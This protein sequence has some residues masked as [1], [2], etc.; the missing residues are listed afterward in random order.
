MNTRF[1][2]ATGGFSSPASSKHVGTQSS[3]AQSLEL[4][5]Q[6]RIDEVSGLREAMRLQEQI[7]N[8]NIA[9]SNLQPSQVSPAAQDAQQKRTDRLKELNYTREKVHMLLQQITWDESAGFRDRRYEQGTK[10]SG[11]AKSKSSRRKHEKDATP[12]ISA[13]VRK[14]MESLNQWVSQDRNVLDV[15]CG[16]GLL[17]DFIENM[18][19][20]HYH[21]ID[22]S[23][24]MI[25]RAR[26][27]LPH[28]H[29][30]QEDFMSF[31]KGA[32]TYS[33]IVFNEC[34]HYMLEPYQALQKAIEIVEPS[35][36]VIVSHPK[37]Y[38]HVNM[39]R[40]KNGMLVASLL[41]TTD[42]LK[43]RVKNM[44]LSIAPSMKSSQYLAVLRKAD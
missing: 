11:R 33:T 38:E 23:R 13:E 16:N 37:G 6:R 4:S 28:A 7:N 42:D 1:L 3:S 14:H 17:Y 25:G 2:L 32:N 22:L 44:E 9:T 15:G 43:E 35:G 24:E 12:V 8:F 19:Q 26:T 29:F 20:N 39:M 21:G 18:D 5:I 41:P 27:K 34:L 30:S 31:D 10:N 36:Y 40:N